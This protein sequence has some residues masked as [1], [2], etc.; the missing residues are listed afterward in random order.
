MCEVELPPRR[1]S[2]TGDVEG[3][4]KFVL[5]V[6]RQLTGKERTAEGP[7]KARATPGAKKPQ[8]CAGGGSV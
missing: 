3:R 7:A 5:D 4:L 8:E 1:V 2:P 6:Y